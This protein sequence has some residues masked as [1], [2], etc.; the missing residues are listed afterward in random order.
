MSAWFIWLQCDDVAEL[1]KF[2]ENAKTDEERQAIDEKI[3]ELEC[4]N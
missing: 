3:A 1:K 4:K 2:R